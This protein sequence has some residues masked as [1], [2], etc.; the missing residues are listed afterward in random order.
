[1]FLNQFIQNIYQGIK[2]RLQ[3]PRKKGL[4]QLSLGWLQ[5]KYLKHLPPGKIRT[6]RLWGRPFY[7]EAPQELLHG[8]QEIFVDE[9]YKQSFRP[10]ARII[11][12]GANVGLSV[13]YFKQKCPSSTIIA[14]EPDPANFSLLEKNIASYQLTGIQVEKLA[15]WKERTLLSFHAQ[16]GMA[17]SLSEST[18]ANTLQVSTARLQ[19]Y[20]QDPVD[21]LKL[22]IE[23]AEWDVLKDCATSLGKVKNIFVEYHGAYAAQE[24]LTT[25]LSILQEA[26]FHYYIR[27][28]APLQLHPYQQ[29]N[30]KH[31]YDIQ[32]NIFGFRN[33]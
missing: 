17:S 32:L 31:P 7:Y 24:K 4:A 3:H 28:A 18:T 23:G 22:D 10:G 11:D 1:M 30:T 19:D 13:L 14:F 8:L 9:V 26:G 6:L 20:L 27:E 15:V 33:G 25:I 12:C 2:T 29:K 5:V 21:F 16:Q